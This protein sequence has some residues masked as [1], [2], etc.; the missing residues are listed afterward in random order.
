MRH[1]MEEMMRRDRTEKA[2]RPGAMQLDDLDDIVAEVFASL[3]GGDDT[4]SDEESMGPQRPVELRNGPHRRTSSS[5]ERREP[6]EIAEEKGEPAIHH[7]KET[8]HS[9]SEREAS[10]N[11][12]PPPEGLN[13]NAGSLALEPEEE[14]FVRQAATWLATRAN[15]ESLL[16]CVRIAIL[17]HQASSEHFTRAAGPSGLSKSIPPAEGEQGG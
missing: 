14:D 16:N 1:G 11:A 13:L 4:V 12:E 5:L 2:P 7:E 10:A 17:E 15:A 9:F 3:D 6:A 8:E